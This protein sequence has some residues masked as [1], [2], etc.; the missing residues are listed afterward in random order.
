LALAACK[1]KP[2]PQPLVN[3]TAPVAIAPSGQPAPAAPIAEPE[4]PPAAQVPPPPPPR[5]PE[6]VAP[7]VSLADAAV[8]EHIAALKTAGAALAAWKDGDEPQAKE[9]NLKTARTSL[10]ELAKMRKNVEPGKLPEWDAA[11]QEARKDF[12]TFTRSSQQSQLS[13]TQDLINGIRKQGQQRR[14]EL[15]KKTEDPKR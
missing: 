11:L 12:L 2:A 9:D 10:M 14:E 8:Q 15:Q 1:E 7:P 13:R 6:P 3:T 4:A 5:P